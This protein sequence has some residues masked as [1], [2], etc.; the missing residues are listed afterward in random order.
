M[1]IL[2]EV[3]KILNDSG[4]DYCVQNKYEMMPE[5]IPSDI[6]MMYQGAD[7]KFFDKVMAEI[8]KKTKLIITQKVVHDYLQYT[9]VFTPVAPEKEYRL[10]L[11]F[12]RALSFKKYT[13]AMPGEQM[14]CGKR[15]HKCFYIPAPEVEVIY[16]IMRRIIKKDLNADHIKVI[17][18]LY[19]RNSE[20][21]SKH[22]V[23]T[24]GSVIGQSL[25]DMIK[26]EDC[27]IFYN[28]L[29]ELQKKLL[30]ICK[31]NTGLAFRINI[32]K[33][34]VTKVIPQRILNPIGFSVAFVAPDGAGKSTVISEIENTCAGSFYGIEKYY[35]RPHLFKNIGSYNVVN[36]HD[37][38]TS[39]SDPHGVK[40]DSKPKSIVRFFF[41]QMDFILGW[42]LKI[43]KNLI[44]KKLVLFDRYYFDYYADML[45][46]KYSLSSS[47]AE[48]LTWMIPKP[49]ITIVLDGKAEVFYERKQ[50]LTIKEINLQL[51]AFQKI[52]KYCSNVKY[53][54]ADQP[55]DN[56][57]NCVT[58][59]ILSAKAR[60][61]LKQFKLGKEDI[62]ALESIIK[63]QEGG[64]HAET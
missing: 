51:E 37:E 21:V 2:E 48:K 45:R 3:F 52:K 19:D 35:F 27:S 12:Y 4:L 55:I 49:D 16:Q 7:E 17:K 23:D 47:F 18:R 39:N 28:K 9:Y 14:L 6:D 44:Q 62:R 46:Y 33:F 64:K 40:L 50:E 53:V 32:A 42:H 61:T 24:F 36:P 30:N 26:M 63:L 1:L 15:M 58:A 31:Q 41:Y 11:D 29:D 57:R 34:Y 20:Q 59:E 54:A 25:I 56:V 60:K 5:E 38:G 13:N 22:I 8:S 43:K 10:Q